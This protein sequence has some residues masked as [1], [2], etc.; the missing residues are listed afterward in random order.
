MLHA[1]TTGS[2]SSRKGFRSYHWISPLALLES[3]RECGLLNA[4]VDLIIDFVERAF[5][6]GAGAA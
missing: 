3:G 6:R 2:I 5:E 4:C 1:L